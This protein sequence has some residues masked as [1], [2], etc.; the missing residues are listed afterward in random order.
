MKLIDFLLMYD[1][2]DRDVCVYDDRLNLIIRGNPDVIMSHKNLIEIHV[3]AFGIHDN[4]LC[5][6]VR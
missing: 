2:W 1:N 6:R 4:E 5:V 3:V